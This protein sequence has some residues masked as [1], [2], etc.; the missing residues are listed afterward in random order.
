VERFFNSEKKTTFM[1]GVGGHGGVKNL[2]IVD[3]YVSWSFLGGAD[4]FSHI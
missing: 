4:H 3:K 2:K 1:P